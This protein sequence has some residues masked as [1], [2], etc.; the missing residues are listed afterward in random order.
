MSSKQ[1][2]AYQ[3]V[4]VGLGPLCPDHSALRDVQTLFHFLGGR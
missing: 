1:V 2:A 3:K 4:L